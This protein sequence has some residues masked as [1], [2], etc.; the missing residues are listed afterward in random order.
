MVQHL[1]FDGADGFKPNAQNVYALDDAFASAPRTFEA[2]VQLD[3]SY[4][5]RAGVIIG[6]YDGGTGNQF[7][8]EVYTSG[9]LRLYYIANRTA[10]NYNFKTDI[11]SDS[12]THIT[13][14][15]DGRTAKLYLD[16]QCKETVTLPAAIP[17]IVSG[18]KIGGDNRVGNTQ[19]FKGTIYTACL[20]SDVRTSEEIAVDRYLPQSDSDNLLVFKN[21]LNNK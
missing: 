14:T 5:Q 11:R 13:L 17:E 19:Y 2:V 1:V 15:V 10:Y 7:N 21:F 12:P 20:F 9:K 16:G 18:Y 6:N 4:T 8:L 3:T